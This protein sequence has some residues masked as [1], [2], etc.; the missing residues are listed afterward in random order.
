MMG[1]VSEGVRQSA[2]QGVKP[3]S[4]KGEEQHRREWGGDTHLATGRGGKKNLR[5]CVRRGEG[6]STGG[7]GARARGIPSFCY[8]CNLLAMVKCHG[9][10]RPPEYSRGSRN[11][12]HRGK[13]LLAFGSACLCH[14]ITALSY[15]N[16]HNF[17][18]YF[19]EQRISHTFDLRYTSCRR[20]CDTRVFQEVRHEYG[21]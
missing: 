11:A 14:H 7:A 8:L 20:C 3:E 6:D 19:L 1:R 18:F 15:N 10:I 13:D 9:G 16:Y 21:Q 4:R 12:I 5:R 17:A 2:S